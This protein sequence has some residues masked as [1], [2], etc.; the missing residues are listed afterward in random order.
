MGS[1]EDEVVNGKGRLRVGL[2]EEEEEG[3]VVL[4]VLLRDEGLARCGILLGVRRG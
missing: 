4:L 2:G 1:S 3:F